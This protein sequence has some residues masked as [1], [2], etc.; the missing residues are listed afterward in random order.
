MIAAIVLASLTSADVGAWLDREVAGGGYL[1][2]FD[3]VLAAVEA[4][5]DLVSRDPEDG[6]RQSV[7]NRAWIPDLDARVGTDRSIDVRDATTT[8]WVRTGQ[9]FGVQV[10][11]RWSFADALFN[12]SVLKVDKSLRDR[13]SSR[14]QARDRVVKLYFDRIEVEMRHLAKPSPATAVAAARG[15]GLLRAVTGGRIRF[16]TRAD[17]PWPEGPR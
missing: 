3:E 2:S 16:G 4:E 6:W 14:W 15:D 7:R 11:L 10:R 13:G 12:D 5:L 1:P 9:G 8:S 17:N